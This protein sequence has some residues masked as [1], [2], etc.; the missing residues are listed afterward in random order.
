MEFLE[1][2]KY[3]YLEEKHRSYLNQLKDYCKKSTHLPKHHIYPPCGLLNDPNGLCYFEGKYHVFYQ[4]FPF[5]PEHG[6]KHWAH[7]I[8]ED[9]VHWEWSEEMLVPD[10]EFEKN[11]CYSGN[12]IGVGGKQYL[13]Y[14]ANYKTE[15]GKVPKQAL[16]VMSKDGSIHKYS[17][18]P[19]IDG[20]PEGMAG[21][22][23]DPFV[24][25]KDGSYYMMLGGADLHGNGQVLVYKS[26]D[27]YNWDYQ[28]NLNLGRSDLGTMF[29]CPAYMEI[30]GK[31]VLLLSL[32]G[33]EA[34]GE[35]FRNEFTT[36][37]FVGTIDL[38][39]LIFETESMEELDKGFDFYAPQ[40]FC[41]KGGR[42]LMFGWF[43]C[44][45]QELP[46][47][48][49]DMWQHALTLPREICVRDS[50]LYQMPAQEM[51]SHFPEL[52]IKRGESL[53]PEESTWRF[54]FI[55][56]T[57]DKTEIFIGES[58]DCLKIVVDPVKGQF[59]ADRSGLKQKISE[60]YGTQR[61]C[62]LDIYK[63]AEIDLYYDN[64]FLEIYIDGGREVMSM[65]L[66]P[67]SCK[68]EMKERLK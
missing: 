35:R 46:Y 22:I 12:S 57:E 66:F 27:L 43:G 37:C 7:V 48:R 24:F 41:G 18:N 39:D 54:H 67:K 68:V 20:A 15:H 42:P 55:S 28:G 30:D 2:E 60:T 6:M 26:V 49:E 11:G 8:S 16:A 58:D 45:V 63:T 25:E 44:G 13:F 64:T 53:I 62:P 19:V 17:G 21:E 1:V 51:I 34:Q 40:M 36:V 23:R 5:A 50:R 59:I 3:T 9:L 47:S 32:I 61:I 56:D 65:R 4:W 33:H 14:T 38:N 52:N 31:D 29:E 10:Q